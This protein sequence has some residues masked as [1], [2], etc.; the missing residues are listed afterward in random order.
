MTRTGTFVT[1][2]FSVLGVCIVGAILIGLVSCPPD[3]VQ[4]AQPADS[5]DT[6]SKSKAEPPGQT[7]C[8]DGTVS[9]SVGS[10]T[11][12]HHG[13]AV[14]DDHVGPRGGQYHYSSSGKKVYDHHR[15]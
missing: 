13:G 12:S 9:P 6:G 4:Y 1:T 8:A 2:L 15:R 11:C 3:R 7:V 5:H 10:G 14:S